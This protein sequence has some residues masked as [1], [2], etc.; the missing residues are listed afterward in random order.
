M[1]AAMLARALV[2]D[3]V[4]EFVGA[5]DEVGF[6]EDAGGETTEEAGLAVFEDLSARAEQRGAGAQESAERDEIVFVAAGAVE[7]E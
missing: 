3:E 4:G 5:M 2:F 7:E 1:D 6:V